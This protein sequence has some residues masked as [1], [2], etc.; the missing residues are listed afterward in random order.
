MILNQSY[1]MCLFFFLSG[2]FTPSSYDRKG[3]MRFLADKLQRLGI[4]FLAFTFV[5]GP[6]LMMYIQNVTADSLDGLQRNNVNVTDLVP[7]GYNASLVGKPGYQMPIHLPGPY[8]TRYF[9]TA[10]PTWFLLWLLILNTCY[11]FLMS[12]T[13]SDNE[14][15]CCCTKGHYHMECPSVGALCACGL[16]VG[17]VTGALIFSGL[18][19]P[20][21]M[22]LTFGSLPG[23]LLFFTFGIVAKRNGWLDETDDTDDNTE[24]IESIE[25]HSQQHSNVFGGWLS[26][27]YRWCHTF[28]TTTTSI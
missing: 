17:L 22:P 14:R 5:L 2:Y 28:Q 15:G 3:P 10:G 21:F 7:R 25:Q 6:M 20:L 8:S 1:F 4:P 26:G 27:W 13:T 11:A 9:P 19:G 18:P 24:Q 23:D 16:L 12:S